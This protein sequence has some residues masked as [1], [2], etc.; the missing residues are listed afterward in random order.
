MSK[1]KALY[2]LENIEALA[3]SLGDI[4]TEIER[5]ES[6]VLSLTKEARDEVD[7]IEEVEY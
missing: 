2:V 3:S 5:L 4:K 6:E 7:E 1:E